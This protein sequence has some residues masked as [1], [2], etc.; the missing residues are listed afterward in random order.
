[1]KNP[2]L[3]KDDPDPFVADSETSRSLQ[4]LCG[5]SVHGTR[6]ERVGVSH[7]RVGIIF[8]SVMWGSVLDSPWVQGTGSL[9]NPE[10]R[11]TPSYVE[12]T[13]TTTLQYAWREIY[14][15]T[16]SAQ[17]KRKSNLY[18]IFFNFFFHPTC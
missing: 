12:L 14:V 11:R 16:E 2:T 8:F 6:N 18:Y 1:M 17:N 3:I 10:T 5:C 15:Q 4:V 7:E 9:R 13:S